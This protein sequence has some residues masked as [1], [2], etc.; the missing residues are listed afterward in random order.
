MCGCVHVHSVCVVVY[1]CTVFVCAVVYVCTVF[2]CVAVYMCTV[3]VYVVVYLYMC[4]VCVHVHFS[5]LHFR[6]SRKMI[7]PCSF[8]FKHAEG[9]KVNQK[10]MKK[11]S[12]LETFIHSHVYVHICTLQFTI[13]FRER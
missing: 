3:F 10:R 8:L 2:V 1:M 6:H 4:S 7:K 5:L 9:K 11:H 13:H 12:V